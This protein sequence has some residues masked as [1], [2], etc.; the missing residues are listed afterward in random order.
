MNIVIF[1]RQP[2]LGIAEIESM[3][4][5]KS[6]AHVHDGFA[7]VEHDDLHI[8]RLGGAMKIG[9]QLTSVPSHDWQRVAQK[10]GDFLTDYYKSQPAG[11]IT[12]GMSLHGFKLSPAKINAAGLTIKKSLK[13]KTRPVRIVPNKETTLSTAQV[14]HNNLTNETNIELLIVKSGK[15][16]IIAKTTQIQ[17]INAYTAR[18]RERPARDARVGMLPPKLAQ[19]IINLARPQSN[20]VVLDPFCGTGVVLQ[21]ALLMG[22]PSVYGTDLE[23]R[24][25][26]Y[27]NENIAWLG[28]TFQLPAADVITEVGDATNHTWQPV[29]DTIACETYLGRALTQAPDRET[30]RKIITDCDTIHAKFLKN[31]TEQTQSGFRMCIA[32]PAWKTAQG[33]S[34]MPV[35]DNLHKLGYNR[36]KFIHVSWQDLIYHRP[37]Q[38]VARELVVLERI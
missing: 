10:L 20:A 36:V 8:N 31:V 26:D 7:L 5:A 29:P 19:I 25:I 16:T 17:D 11:K 21:E 3:Y 12:I 1:G 14:L 18:D 15:H 23:P 13:S 30:L 32:V 28:E 34:H 24:M 35:L 4:G 27:T 33:F 2:A 22:F 38:V 37:G 6:I 9:E